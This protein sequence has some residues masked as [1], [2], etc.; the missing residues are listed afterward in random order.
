ME[1]E[2]EWLLSSKPQR[3]QGDKFV[4][5]SRVSIGVGCSDFTVGRIEWGVRARMI[6]SLVCVCFG[7]L[8]RDSTAVEV[9]VGSVAEWRFVVVEEV[10]GSTQ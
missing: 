10:D 8:V 6:A 1:V 7:S 5:S 4:K 9:V 2:L 3:V